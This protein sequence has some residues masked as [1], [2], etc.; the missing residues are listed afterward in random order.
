MA[1]W[2]SIPDNNRAKWLVQNHPGLAR[3]FQ[4]LAWVQDGLSEPELRAVDELASLGIGEL[5]ALK[6]VLA[7]PWVQDAISDAESDVISRLH[8]LPDPINWV[9][10]PFLE[11]IESSDALALHGVG[12][13]TSTGVISADA[14]LPIFQGGITNEEAILIAAAGTIY[15][16]PPEAQRLLE[17]GVA[18]VETAELGT[19]LTPNLKISIVRT[20][21]QEP[22][23]GTIG[24]L[25]DLLG[26]V[27]SKMWIPLPHDHVIVL[28]S[29][30]GRQG[31][32]TVG[33]NLGFAFRIF[34][35]DEQQRDTP[36]WE[37]WQTILVHEIAHYY[38]LEGYPDWWLSEGMANTIDTM[39]RREVLG[40]SVEQT[41]PAWGGC[42][43]DNLHTLTTTEYI[44]W[45]PN[46][47]E[48]VN[49][50]NC[51]YY[52]GEL[53]FGDLLDS[54][55]QE[56]FGHRLAEFYRINSARDRQITPGIEVVRQAFPDQAEI[57]EKHWSGDVNAPENRP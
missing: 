27:E 19:A 29:G 52:L 30:R 54:M 9:R 39:F 57:V 24:A 44:G 11:S 36:R 18:T 43:F 45:D 33:A 2:D 42:P 25:R 38:W 51:W 31:T 46:D 32:A 35:P 53:L 48:S 15:R 37:S 55:G 16:N 34:P 28:F 17:P 1:T 26:F 12:P 10:M 21:G 23:Q 40:R 3:Q 47:R 8:I 56:A 20:D 49:Q 4:D 41:Q 5:E 6:S 7:L 14:E 50:G 22:W 13:L